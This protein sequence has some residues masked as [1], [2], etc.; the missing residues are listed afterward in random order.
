MYVYVLVN[1][2]CHG[3]ISNKTYIDDKMTFSD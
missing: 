2:V 3:K 1:C